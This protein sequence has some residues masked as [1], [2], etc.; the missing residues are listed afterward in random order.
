MQG[1][2]RGPEGEMTAISEPKPRSRYA[3]A[4]TAGAVDFATGT[5]ARAVYRSERPR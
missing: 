5:H 2:G 3:D 4:W 1:A